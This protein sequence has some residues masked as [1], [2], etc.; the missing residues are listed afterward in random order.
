MVMMVN[1]KANIIL[2]W[3]T[4]SACAL[5]MFIALTDINIWPLSVAANFL[6][7]GLFASLIAIM[8][9]IYHRKS[10]YI[11]AAGII[12]SLSVWQL[13]TSPVLS[14]FVVKD[15][16]PSPSSSTP[17]QSMQEP[18]EIRIA[19]INLFGK[20]TAVEKLLKWAKETQPDIIAMTELP[21]GIPESD[22]LYDLFK[23]YSYR[24][25][26]E[27][28]G[29]T[30]TLIASR[31]PITDHQTWSRYIS[32]AEITH[33]SGRVLSV[34]SL[35]PPPPFT[36]IM[37]YR[38]DV[39]ISRAFDMAGKTDGPTI[40]LGDFNTAPW[41]AHMK[42]NSKEAGMARV[43]YRTLATTWMSKFPF[44][45]L[46]IDHIYTSSQ[47]Q[48]IETHTGPSLGS[49][50]YPLIASLYLAPDKE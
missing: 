8:V 43:E 40:V 16:L 24:T 3:L 23:I 20:T 48:R 35:H 7:Q 33:A 19:H 18:L 46:P 13:N 4:I 29:P 41:T 37:E 32:R 17:S 44:I 50:H 12:I 30:R 6:I 47:F 27:D 45:G 1:P 49:D 5:P 38:R 2:I 25:F 39:I 11:A 15:K 42:N 31:F 28:G 14:S 34:Y 9:A 26:S 10:A 22:I 36:P 21:G